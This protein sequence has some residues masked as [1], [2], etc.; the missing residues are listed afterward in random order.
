MSEKYGSAKKRVSG[1]G[2]TRAI[3]FVRLAARAR[4]AVLGT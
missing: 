1:S 2:T 4:A 3:A